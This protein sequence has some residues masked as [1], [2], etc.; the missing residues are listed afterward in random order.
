MNL[1][2]LFTAKKTGIQVSTLLL[3][4][5]IAGLMMAWK[6]P[7]KDKF[8][9]QPYKEEVYHNLPEDDK[10]DPKHAVAGLQTAEGLETTLFAAEPTL[11]NPTNI[12]VDAKGR[13]WVCE[14]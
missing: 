6:K 10:R 12:D 11:T 7:F 9:S 5:L 8:N 2:R 3:C 13:V 14:A 4:A 1:P